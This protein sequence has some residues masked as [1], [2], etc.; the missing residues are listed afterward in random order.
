MNP[1][2]TSF[3]FEPIFIALPAAAAVAYARARRRHPGSPG[4]A[5]LFGLGLAIVVAALNSPLETVAT[6]YLL[7]AHLLQNALIADWA[8]PLLLLGLPPGMRAALWQRGGSA[9][10]TITRPTI[11]LPAWLATWYGIHAGGIY[12]F[13]LRHPWALNLE[14][15]LLIA[16]GLCFWWP[17]V[18]E[19]MSA[20]AMLG[21]LATAF[22]GATFLGLALTFI[23]RPFYDFYVAAPR[24]WGIGVLRD[25]SLAGA[26]MN[27]E[28]AVV[29][30]SAIAWVFFRLLDDPA[31]PEEGD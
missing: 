23:E 24:L 31:E 1:A 2:A 3:T 17:V 14:H 5:V 19:R 29:F 25:Q 27:A 18:T 16:V 7:L 13:A 11:A 20:G 26:L 15:G 30:V 10:A 8:P 21:Y 28:Q 9:I 22:V 12:D 4:Q 6:H